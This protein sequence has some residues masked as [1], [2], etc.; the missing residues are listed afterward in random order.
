MRTGERSASFRMEETNFPPKIEQL[1]TL[2]GRDLVRRMQDG[3]PEGNAL[4]AGNPVQ[5]A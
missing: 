3:I 2:Q 1:I 5:A 4:K